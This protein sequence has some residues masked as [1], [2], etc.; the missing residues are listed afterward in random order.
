MLFVMVSSV[1]YCTNFINLDINSFKSTMNSM[2]CTRYDKDVILKLHSCSYYSINS[3]SNF[4]IVSLIATGK[5]VFTL[6]VILTLL[7]CC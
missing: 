4:A 2:N 5:L 7:Y 1:H 6:V 3:P